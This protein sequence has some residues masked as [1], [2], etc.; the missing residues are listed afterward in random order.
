MAAMFICIKLNLAYHFCCLHAGNHSFLRKI[1]AGR[2]LPAV[3]SPGTL[4]Q[5]SSVTLYNRIDLLATLFS[6]MPPTRT[7]ASR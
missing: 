4:D 1:A 7:R 3:S 6:F 5:D 2:S